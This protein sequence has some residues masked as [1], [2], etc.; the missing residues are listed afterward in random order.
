MHRR[1]RLLGELPRYLK[2]YSVLALLAFFAWG[3]G[4]EIRAVLGDSTSA[5]VK[6]FSLFGASLYAWSMTFAV[7]GLFLRFASGHH[8][9]MRYLADASY[10]VYLWHLP[11]VFW[12]QLEVIKLP[13][14]SWLKLL[15]ILG[16]TLAAL[17]PTYHW[18]VRYTWVGRILNGQRHPVTVVAS[19]E[20]MPGT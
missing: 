7:T 19:A 18:F 3:T 8:P 11:I 4:L 1:L 20:K 6:L 15:L 10:W 17:L 2:T 13:L 5:Y 14:G 16:T 9:W 12:L